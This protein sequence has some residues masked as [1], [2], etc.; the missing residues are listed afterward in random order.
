MGPRSSLRDIFPDQANSQ[1]FSQ[2]GEFQYDGSGIIAL[3]AGQHGGMAHSPFD[4]GSPA[5][6]QQGTGPEGYLM[7]GPGFPGLS[8]AEFLQTLARLDAAAFA[9]HGSPDNAQGF[10]IGLPAERHGDMAQSPSE[11]G[12]FPAVPHQGAGF[13]AE[14]EFDFGDGGNVPSSRTMT[15]GPD[16][17]QSLLIDQALQPAPELDG[18]PGG[19]SP[20]GQGA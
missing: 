5:M 11:Q 9:D 20:S 19:S 3:A 1:G 4:Q 14:G 10:M 8:E 2:P 13:A 6:A 17:D 16:A 7:A 18:Q 12:G 15:P